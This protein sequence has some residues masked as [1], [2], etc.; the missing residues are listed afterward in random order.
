MDKYVLYFIYYPLFR[1]AVSIMP[2]KSLCNYAT[3][4]HCRFIKKTL[5]TLEG[6]SSAITNN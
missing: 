1:N 3:Q 4:L 2:T 6:S 5:P